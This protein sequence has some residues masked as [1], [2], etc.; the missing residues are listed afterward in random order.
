[1]SKYGPSRS[2]MRR[3][4]HSVGGYYNK[5]TGWVIPGASHNCSPFSSSTRWFPSL[6]DAY[7]A[8]PDRK[9]ANEQVHNFGNNEAAYLRS[10]FG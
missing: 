2:T 6:E 7:F 9:E 1:M 5:Q 3:Y 4:I 10:V 8:A